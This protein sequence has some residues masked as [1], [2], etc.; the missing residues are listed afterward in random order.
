[1][2]QAITS[3]RGC[4][5]G[6]A[7]SVDWIIK[8]IIKYCFVLTLRVALMHCKCSRHMQRERWFPNPLNAH[9]RLALICEKL[10]AS[11]GSFAFEAPM[12]SK[13]F[14]KLWTIS[15]HVIIRPILNADC[16][17]S[18]VG[19]PALSCAEQKRWKLKRN[20][21]RLTALMFAITAALTKTLSRKYLKTP[22]PFA[23][24]LAISRK[25]VAREEAKQHKPSQIRKQT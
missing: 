25:A 1:M 13:S 16:I 9:A 14:Q 17:S 20:L 8:A 18:L 12:D 6:A 19:F 24:W 10:A 21:K 2:F 3:N 15:P 11:F 23:L 4:V 5:R 22:C 7:R